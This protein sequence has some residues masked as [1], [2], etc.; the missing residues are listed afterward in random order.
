MTPHI[1]LAVTTL[2][3]CEILFLRLL[4]PLHGPISFQGSA[5]EA[6]H[7]ILS[8]KRSQ[9]KLKLVNALHLNSL[10]PMCFLVQTL[11]PLEEAHDGV[12]RPALST[13]S[14]VP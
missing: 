13:K 1:G 6:E 5:L 10:P 12:L 11:A 9:V 8:R 14:S 7:Q 4:N 3:T 2:T